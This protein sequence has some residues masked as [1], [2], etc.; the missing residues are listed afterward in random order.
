M[1]GQECGQL[2]KRPVSLLDKGPGFTLRWEGCWR[3]HARGCVCLDAR[4]RAC[5]CVCLSVRTSVRIWQSNHRSQ[6]CADIRSPSLPSLPDLVSQL[7]LPRGAWALPYLL[8]L[9]QR[10]RAPGLMLP[11][12]GLPVFQAILPHW[13]QSPSVR[14]QVLG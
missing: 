10:N 14:L 3:A 7:H 6:S 4:V 11:V 13:P 1:P 12:A 2:C 8:V 5:G 9:L